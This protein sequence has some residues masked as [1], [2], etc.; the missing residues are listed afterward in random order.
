MHCWL[1]GEALP[2]AVADQKKAAVGALRG[3]LNQKFGTVAVLDAFGADKAFESADEKDKGI[4]KQYSFYKDAIVAEGIKA[5]NWKDVPES[6]S[7]RV[8]AEGALLLAG[9][10]QDFHFIDDV[11]APYGT[12]EPKLGDGF[13]VCFRDIRAISRMG[14]LE[15]LKGIDAAKLA[16]FCEID[17]SMNHLYASDEVSVY[18]TG[19]LT[20]PFI[21]QMMQNFSLVFGRIGTKDIPPHYTEA[22]QKLVKG[23]N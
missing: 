20:S 4:Q 6:I 10:I 11:E 7:K 13:V 8:T 23:E 22:I 19:E 5:Y 15:I 12:D 9:K 2:K 1:W 16:K 17:F 21:E 14:A 18:P 3:H